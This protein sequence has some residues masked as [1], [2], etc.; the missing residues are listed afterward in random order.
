M[1][2]SGDAV[3]LPAADQ[4]LQPAVSSSAPDVK[5]LGMWCDERVCLKAADHSRSPQV[6]A[7]LYLQRMM[8]CGETS[9]L[10]FY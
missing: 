3:S 2:S 5:P 10:R 7:V 4:L 1:A 9:D 6:T 8:I